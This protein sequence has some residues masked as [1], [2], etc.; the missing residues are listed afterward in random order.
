MTQE[1]HWLMYALLLTTFLSV[2]YVTNRIIMRGPQNA[3]A[4]PRGETGGALS[5]WAQRLVHAHANAVE[6]LVIF[7][8]AVLAVQVLGLSSPL[9]QA[10]AMVFFY[11]RVAHVL[12]YVANVPIARTLA[13]TAGWMA[14]IAIVL[15]VLGWF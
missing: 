3:L 15:H 7:A 10:A 14:Q 4:D 9:T 1:I 11:A 5:P 13:F 2:P 8:A 12:A 6:N